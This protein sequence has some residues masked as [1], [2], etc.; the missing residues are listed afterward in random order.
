MNTPV[1]FFV[2]PVENYPSSEWSP[3]ARNAVNQWC[4]LFTTGTRDD[5][6]QFAARLGLTLS[7]FVDD[8]QHWRYDLTR[9]RR[10]CALNLGAQAVSFDT[11]RGI[12]RRRSV[13]Q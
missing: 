10:Q 2:D 1:E 3:V 11:L 6:H 4:H 13:R 8:E 7:D 9:G 12:L 5:L